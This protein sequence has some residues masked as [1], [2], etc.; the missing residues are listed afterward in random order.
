MKAVSSVSYVCC[1][2]TK[3]MRGKDETIV[4]SGIGYNGFTSRDGHSTDTFKDFGH[5]TTDTIIQ[6]I[7]GAGASY[8]ISI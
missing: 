3:N 2:C 4:L 5:S 1:L 7:G 8:I 6:R